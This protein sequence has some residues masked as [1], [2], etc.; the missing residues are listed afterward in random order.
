[1]TEHHRPLFG[2]RIG[3]ILAA[4][5]SAV[6]LGN[7]WKFPY[8]AGQNG[9][10]AFLLVYLACVLF[11]GVPVM[12]AEF[13]MGRH[14][15]QGAVGAYRRLGIG[16]PWGYAG[17]LGVLGAFLILGYYSVVAGWTAEYL[18]Q[19]ASE[20]MCG[21]QEFKS[22][23]RFAAEFDAFITS[24]VR[25]IL[26]TVL[27]LGLSFAAISFG[28]KHGIELSAKIMMPMLFFL[29][30]ILCVR[31]MTLPG[32]AEGL[33]FFLLPDF[34]KFGSRTVLSAMGQAFFSLS[35]GMG[36]MV[37]YASYFERS[38]NMQATACSVAAID[39]LVAFM[40]GLVIFPAVFSFG[41]AP[42]HGPTLVFVTLP[43]V[44]QQMP[45]GAVWST[46][47][48]L[49][50]V[51]AAIT[52]LISL[53]EVATAYLTDEFHWG[54]LPAAAAVGGGILFFAVFCSL[55]CGVL[56]D[57]KILGLTIFDALDSLTNRVLMPLGGVLVCLFVGWRIDRRILKAELTNKGSVPF[58]FFRCYA[59]FLRY[60]AP[61]A[62]TLILLDQL[63]LFR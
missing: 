29:M 59:F 58:H 15:R 19:S 60:V 34:S 14:T 22:P 57:F 62:I 4:V 17:Y 56:N 9:G 44:F 36:C 63:N 11:L 2:S 54:R 8:E 37:T 26:W 53:Y 41:I 50:L 45:L 3:A 12:L 32:A 35:I 51:I 43:N 39:T 47:F 31:A 23:E 28:V 33:R 24:P 25:P 5:G 20:L 55:S 7:I 21:T 1:M 48:F 52:S 61:I 46:A 10:S 42:E 40:A 38:T 27:V 49:L 13:F 30:I 18:C 6:G 16:S